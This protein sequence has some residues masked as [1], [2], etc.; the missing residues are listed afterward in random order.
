MTSLES[1][2][3]RLNRAKKAAPSV[4]KCS[5]KSVPKI[6]TPIIAYTYAKIIRT[7]KVHRTLG[8]A[9]ITAFTIILNFVIPFTSLR[10]FIIRSDLM[11][12]MILTDLTIFSYK[13]MEY[14]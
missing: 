5:G 7:Q 8:I 2:D 6:F 4:P 1:N 14:F 11:P 12:L 10:V 9:F 13:Q 3:E